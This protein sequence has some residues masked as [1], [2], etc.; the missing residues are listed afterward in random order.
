MLS[1][2]TSRGLRGVPVWTSSSATWP[3]ARGSGQS[4]VQVQAGWR[5]DWEKHWGEGFGG[6]DGWDAQHDPLV[7]AHSPEGQLYPGPEIKGRD[8]CPLLLSSE[9]LPGVLHPALWLQTQ[10][11][12]SPDGVSPEE[13][14]EWGR[15]Q[16]DLFCEDRVRELGLFSLDKRMLWGDLNSNLPAPKGELEES[17]RGTSYKGVQWH[18]KG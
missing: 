10:I 5:K 1:R 11:G 12:C 9:T 7:C 6:V 17:W 18:D 14:H 3:N 13:Q 4:Q 2:G 15:W 8:S 16:G